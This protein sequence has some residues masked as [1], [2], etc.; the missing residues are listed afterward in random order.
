M[1]QCIAC[2]ERKD[3]S[4]YYA[5]PMMADGH[6]GKCKECCKLAA[7]KRYGSKRPEIAE[8]E[9]QRSRTPARRAKARHP[10]KKAARTAVGVALR[11]GRMVRQPC[12]VCGAEKVQAHHED[13]SKPLDVRWL[14]F[15]CHREHAHGQIVSEVAPANDRASPDSKRAA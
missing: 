8:Y 2:G 9:R 4:F 5:H 13:Y 10:E 14:C 11:D 1:K 6:L 3:A 15:R 12:E 7:K